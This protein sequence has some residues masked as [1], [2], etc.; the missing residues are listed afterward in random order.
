M[1]AVV[2][3][4]EEK[5]LIEVR[6]YDTLSNSDWLE[7]LDEIERLHQQW[8]CISVLVD[9]TELIT[10][11][12][13]FEIFATASKKIPRE[14]RFA[15]VMEAEQGISDSVNFLET[16]AWSSGVRIL[17]FN[18]RQDALKWFDMD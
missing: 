11:P 3:F 5:K 14:M 16:I 2:S 10:T 18:N 9:S 7:S 12:R 6:S 15:L 13:T 8:G 4:N 17:V 1:P